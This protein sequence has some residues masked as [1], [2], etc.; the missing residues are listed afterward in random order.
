[1]TDNQKNQADALSL[2]DAALAH[3]RSE[4]TKRGSGVGIRLSV[5]EVG[6]SGLAYVVDFVDAPETDDVTF[7]ITDDVTLCVQQD[8][9]E[10]LSGTRLDYVRRGLN[11][12]FEFH[13]PNATGVCGCGESF[14]TK[15]T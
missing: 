8:S 5:K 2:T 15:S 12:G 4:L 9:F 7:S 13:N 1:M 11:E 14:T 6:C 3:V 10:F